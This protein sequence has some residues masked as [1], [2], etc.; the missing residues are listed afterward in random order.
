MYMYVYI[1]VYICIYVCIYIY[2]CVCVRACVCMNINNRGIS[3]RMGLPLIDLSII[4]FS[5]KAAT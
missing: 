3:R 2:I 5:N 4:M 1:Y